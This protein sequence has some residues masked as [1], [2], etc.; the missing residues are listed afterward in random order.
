[1]D[2]IFTVMEGGNWEC[3]LEKRMGQNE[4]KAH[5]VLPL[6]LVALGF[7]SYEKRRRIRQGLSLHT[8]EE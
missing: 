7:V 4:R 5:Y 3:G 2:S 8:E 6:Y 1:M